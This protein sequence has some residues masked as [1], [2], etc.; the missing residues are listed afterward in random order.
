MAK[1]L[2]IEV[3]NE[4]RRTDIEDDL[5]VLA[6][7]D[8]YVEPDAG[9]YVDVDA[10]AITS[11]YPPFSPNRLA[12]DLLSSSSLFYRVISVEDVP[13]VE[14]N[15]LPLLTVPNTYPERCERLAYPIIYAE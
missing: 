2:R 9:I 10:D 5:L 11:R 8:T 13:A 1:R 3:F 6:R 4:V 14:F 15:E 7:G 12:V